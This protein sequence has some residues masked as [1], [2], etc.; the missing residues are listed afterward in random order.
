MGPGNGTGLPKC[1]ARS[2]QPA[3]VGHV[4]IILG[5]VSAVLCLNSRIPQIWKNYRRRAVDGLSWVMFFCA[6]MGNVTYALGVFLRDV[7]KALLAA[8]PFLVGSVG[9]ICLDGII[10]IQFWLYKGSSA[11]TRT[12]S[13]GGDGTYV[14]VDSDDDDPL[15]QSSFED[16]RGVHNIRAWH[17]KS[18]RWDGPSPVREMRGCRGNM[19]PRPRDRAGTDERETVSTR[20]CHRITWRCFH[21]LLACK[22]HPLLLWIAIIYNI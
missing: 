1:D 17:A 20:V 18:P 15:D 14:L 5:W 13:V 3:W 7:P 6:V 11:N 12:S 22:L 21:P 4:G 2:P 16:I 9:T 19:T 8:L 10:L